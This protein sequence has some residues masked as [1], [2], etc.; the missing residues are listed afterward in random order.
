[1]GVVGASVEVLGLLS[2]QPVLTALLR[3][4]AASAPG[5]IDS[6][7]SKLFAIVAHWLC[8]SFCVDVHV[9]RVGAS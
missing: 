4:A 3:I 2:T 6:L 9:K 5:M 8:Q 1:M 7:V